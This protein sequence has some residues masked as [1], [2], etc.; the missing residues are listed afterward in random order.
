MQQPQKQI[1][2]VVS[3]GSIISLLLGLNAWFLSRLVETLDSTTKTVAELRIDVAV[4]K[5]G[6][7][8]AESKSKRREAHEQTP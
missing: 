6:I 5:Y 4:L 2:L 8:D 3:A 7:R 1:G